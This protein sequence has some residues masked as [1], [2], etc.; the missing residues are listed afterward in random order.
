MIY[1]LLALPFSA[2]FL[3]LAGTWRNEREWHSG[4]GGKCK[5]APGH[6]QKSQL[7]RI[8]KISDAMYP[9]YRGFER[10][11]C[12]SDCGKLPRSCR[13]CMVMPIVVP[14]SLHSEPE[15]H[16]FSYHLSR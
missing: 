14:C 6:I 1:T 2:G 16:V 15:R 5:P 9:M 12:N 7:H 11:G 8:W 3:R 10:I 13:R 4:L